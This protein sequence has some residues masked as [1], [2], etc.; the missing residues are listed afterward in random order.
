MFWYSLPLIATVIVI[1][2]LIIGH[3]ARHS[4][5][6][7][8]LALMTLGILS[9]FLFSAGDMGVDY[10]GY[11]F[12]YVTMPTFMQFFNGAGLLPL[13]LEPG[14]QFIVMTAKSL[15]LGVRGPVLL[16]YFLACFIFLKGCKNGE[17]PPLT[18]TALF[19]LLI[20][21]DFY[22]QQRM[23]FICACGICII[24]YLN[25]SRPLGIILVTLLAT[26]FQ[27]VALAYFVALV[28]HYVDK[29]NPDYRGFITRRIIIV[30]GRL[31]K[32][33]LRDSV[34][35]LF[36]VIILISFILLATSVNQAII[37]Q[38]VGVLEYGFARQLPIVEK[39]LS[40]YSRN[41]EIS[42]SFLGFLSTSLFILIII[43]SYNAN[44]IYWKLRYGL[45][46]LILA[47]LSFAILSP[48]P[49]VSYRVVQLFYLP[50]LMYIG[51]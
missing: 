35:Y 47:L 38:V 25:K 33:F 22:G 42:L 6:G 20:Y 27:Y 43:F 51:S 45:V 39:F 49:F 16:L 11:K 28:F 41:S 9:L 2:D 36:P 26:M 30:L 44:P 23:A 8:F 7:Y 18:V 31:R 37:L 19:I 13:N 12:F 21:P 29:R 40:Y 24:G 3:N 1:I 46:F 50:G 15:G 32:T 14:F 10:H 34:T 4:A 17:L 48:L 5:L